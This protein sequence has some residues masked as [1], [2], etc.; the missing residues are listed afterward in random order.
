[1]LAVLSP[2]ALPAVSFATLKRSKSQSTEHRRLDIAHTMKEFM[3]FEQTGRDMG[4]LTSWCLANA[5]TLRGG[6]LCV[7]SN[8]TLF[9]PLSIGA[10]GGYR[11]AGQLVKARP[12]K[13]TL[14]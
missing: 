12:R 4:K 5:Q 2:T 8:R 6:W 3:W 14:Q 10:V 1:M 9:H 13:N 11:K 7:A